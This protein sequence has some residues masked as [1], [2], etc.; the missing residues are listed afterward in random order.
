MAFDQTTRNRLARFVG[1]CRELLSEEF[2]RQLQS[3]YGMDPKTG[4]FADLDALALSSTQFETARLLRE[5]L[6]HYLASM[7]TGTAVK[8]KKARLDALSRIVREQAFT[9]LNRLCAIRMAEAR[10]LCIECISKGYQSQ[11]FQLYKTLA[12]TALGEIGDTYRCFLF[13]LFDEFAVDLPVLFDRFSPQGRLFPRETALL[14]VLGEINHADIDPLWAEDETIGWIYQYFNSKEER[15]A[16]RDTK[17]GGSQAPRNSRELAVRNQFFTPRYVVEFLTDNTLGRI[18]YEMTQGTTALKDSCRYLVRRPNEIFLAEHEVTATPLPFDENLSD[19]IGDPQEAYAEVFPQVEA[20]QYS[21]PTGWIQD[22]YEGNFQNLPED[23]CDP[24]AAWVAAAVPPEQINGL[25]GEKWQPNEDDTALTRLTQS[26]LDGSP[27]DEVRRLPVAWAVLSAFARSSQYSGGYERE[28]RQK[29]WSYFRRLA[30]E[31]Q[32][33]GPDTGD[34]SQEELLKQPV[35]IPH[36]PLKDPR[37]LKMLDPAC[38]SMHFGLYAFDLFERIYEEAW[39]LEDP[40]NKGPDAFV[41][42]EGLKPLHETY[43]SKD[44]FLR[45]VPRL[46][47]ERNIHGIDI[48]PRAVQIAGLSLWLRAQKSWQTQGVA[49]GDRPQIQRSNIV[50]AEPMP[51]EADMLEDFLKGL[52]DDRLESLIRRVLDVPENQQ[53]RATARMAEALCDLVRTVWKEMELAGE[54]GSLLKIEDSLADAIAKGKDEWEAKLPLFRVTEFGLTEKMQAKPKVKYYKTVPG[55][56]EDFWSRAGAMVLEALENY[57][58][59]AQ[60]TE[61]SRRQ[62]FVQDAARGFAFIDL[63]RNR[64]DVALMNPPFG[65]S[66]CTAKHYIDSEYRPWRY[67]IYPCFISRIASSLGEGG[68]LGYLAPRTG[69]YSHRMQAWREHVLLG[70]SQLVCLADLGHGVLDDAL[71]EVAAGVLQSKCA[72]PQVISFNC[73]PHGAAVK[74]SHLQD[75][76]QD[77]RGV[78]TPF[79]DIRSLPGHKVI[80]NAPPALL[81]RFSVDDPLDPG[82]ATARDGAHSADNERYVRLWWEVPVSP[83]VRS[84]WPFYAKGGEYA[85]YF[86]NPHLVINWCNAGRDISLGAH[87]VLPSQR[88]YFLSGITYTERTASVFNARVLP[89]GCIFSQ[90]GP[91]VRPHE[92]VSTLGLLG[93]LMTIAVR[94]IIELLVGSGDGAVSGSAARH[95]LSGTIS[96]IP[97]PHLSTSE[98]QDIANGT[99]EIVAATA[100]LQLTSETD[101]NFVGIGEV[102]ESLSHQ[103]KREH[104]AYLRSV[105]TILDRS[106]DIESTVCEVF[107]VGELDAVICAELVSDHPAAMPDREVDPAELEVFESPSEDEVVDAVAASVRGRAAT[108]QAFFADRRVELACL[109]QKASP[110]SI[111]SNWP[112]PGTW[113]SMRRAHDV[114]SIAIGIAFGRWDASCAS[115]TFLRNGFKCDPLAPLPPHPPVYGD[116]NNIS[117]AVLASDYAA[118]NDLG[119]AI[120]SVLSAASGREDVS[121]ESQMCDALRVSS[122]SE[123]LITPSGFFERHLSQYSKSRRYAPIY[124]PLS[125]PSSSYTLW[126]YYH[127]VTDQT[128]YTCVND[129]VEPKLKQV[130]DETSRLRGK[131][132]RSSAEEKELERLSDLELE[133]K[134]FRDELLRIAKFWK[135]DLNDGVQITAAPLWK[136]FQHRQWQSRLK[137]TW[138]KLEAGEYDWAHLALSIWPDRVVRASHKDRSYAIAHDLEDPLWHEVEVEKVGRGGRVTTKM[139]WQ[140]RDLS[141]SKLNQIIAGVKAR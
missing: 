28:G 101:I 35:H 12:G 49:A 83:D 97:I 74:G 123:D 129:F 29:L 22:A 100:C 6:D 66:S 67:D 38:G 81:H 42:P 126:L 139:E 10:E 103:V 20:S 37:D 84:N 104:Q 82:Y 65:A 121:L 3:I 64:F 47:I 27:V 124:W 138:E 95:F 71:V 122:L 69:Y 117:Q 51:G 107:G 2:T 18:W 40:G 34:L 17:R 90:A 111:I 25:I 102:A 4:E 33:Y 125:T 16:M 94:S 75:Q 87:S 136:L 46:I 114:L 23:G 106:Y 73:L 115:V 93:Y 15:Q 110:Q 50:C 60:G 41:R 127:R 86:A 21:P 72:L 92:S 54:A 53:V 26:I 108:K 128:L 48:D 11:G 43:G 44:A 119:R 79:E 78:L 5:T 31:W 63:W 45:D 131:S 24:G 13:R 36:R 56:E 14:A 57:A 118:S 9:V 89:A 59:Q 99:A 141:D 30:Q 7:D 52:R 130:S 8:A 140:P 39:D 98:W 19:I 85:P 133:L 134:D 135:P 58:D 80:L 91:M 76:L 116:E 96:S 55:E 61:A 1:D 113:R 112:E 62:M 70:D 68:R 120:S 137:E 77:H 105:Q 32:Q 109:S 88:V 132:N